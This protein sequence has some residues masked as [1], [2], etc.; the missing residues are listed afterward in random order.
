MTAGPTKPAQA[1]AMKDNVFKINPRRCPNSIQIRKQGLREAKGLSQGHTASQELQTLQRAALAT[2]PPFQGPCQQPQETIGPISPDQAETLRTL[3]SK[4]PIDEDLWDRL[5]NLWGGGKQGVRSSV[6]ATASTPGERGSPTPQPLPDAEVPAT[7]PDQV[8]L[9]LC[10]LATLDEAHTTFN[11]S[12]FHFPQL[13]LQPPPLALTLPSAMSIAP[14][15]G[16][17]CRGLQPS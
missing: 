12:P 17:A 14:A 8:F 1:A 2:L 16:Q 5:S 4:A 10:L 6:R 7:P 11:Y 9:R 13:K 15:Q 3:T